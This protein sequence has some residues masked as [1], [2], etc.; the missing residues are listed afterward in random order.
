MLKSDLDSRWP[1]VL[2]YDKS[3]SQ[4]KSSASALTICFILA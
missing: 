3:V 1:G 2:Q 4:Q